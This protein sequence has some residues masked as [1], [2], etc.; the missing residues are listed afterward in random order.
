MNIVYPVTPND[1]STPGKRL[2]IARMALGLPKVELAV[3]IFRSSMFIYNQVIKGKV[4]FP[5]EWAYMLKDYYGINMDWLY[6]GKGEIYIKNLGDE[7][8]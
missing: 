2:D 6:Y 3:R 8:A 5:L 1:L 7:N 4:L